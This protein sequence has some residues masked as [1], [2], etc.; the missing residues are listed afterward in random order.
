MRE[1]T[2][3]PNA[4]ELRRGPKALAEALRAGRFSADVLEDMAARFGTKSTQ[5]FVR[6]AL[7]EAA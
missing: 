1:A 3:A 6:S 2:I 5:A 7:D 4:G